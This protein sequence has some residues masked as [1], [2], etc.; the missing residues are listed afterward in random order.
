MGWHDPRPAWL[1]QPDRAPA[2]SIRSR[3][4]DLDALVAVALAADAQY[5]YPADLGEVA[6]VG[7]TTGLVVDAGYFEQAHRLCCINLVEHNL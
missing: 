4:P 1:R 7:A 6:D 2:S 5:L 3:E